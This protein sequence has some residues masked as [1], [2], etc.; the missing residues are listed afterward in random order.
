MAYL[1]VSDIRTQGYLEA[2]Y[3]D[4]MVEEAIEIACESVD[5]ICR[6]W[7]E[8]R[9][10]VRTYDGDGTDLLVLDIPIIELTTVELLDLPG[11]FTAFSGAELA[12]F[13]IYN[14]PKDL[15][16]PR[17]KIQPRTGFGFRPSC[18]PKGP[19]TV[20]L[21][22][23]FGYTLSGETPA[24]IK[25]AALELATLYLG[26]LASGEPQERLMDGAKVEEDTDDNRVKW[27]ASAAAG[28][29]TGIASVD[30][31]LARYRRKGSAAHV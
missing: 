23:S 26:T 24:P 14:Q 9:D 15:T 21:T 19:L 12:Y 18:F 10:D 7:F 2:D 13:A 28:R 22:G 31:V 4:P 6:Q 3:D 11:N 17:I 29:L 27:L 30:R 8:P 25:R 20:R 16:Y 1:D 5:Q